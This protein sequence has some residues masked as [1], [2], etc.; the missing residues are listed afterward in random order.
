[1][2]RTAFYFTEPPPLPAKAARTGA[3]SWNDVPERPNPLKAFRS[4]KRRSMR[5]NGRYLS[6]AGVSHK[7]LIQRW[8]DE[9]SARMGA[10]G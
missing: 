10:R 2:R 1:V 6:Q 9:V 7:E 5:V 4:S 8:A 3:D